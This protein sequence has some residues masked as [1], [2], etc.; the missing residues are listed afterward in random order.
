[1]FGCIW[2]LLGHPSRKQENLQ[3]L[4]YKT[5]ARKDKVFNCWLKQWLKWG[6][7]IH[8]SLLQ[9]YPVTSMTNT[10]AFRAGGSRVICYTGFASDPPQWQKLSNVHS[11]RS[12]EN[13]PK[14]S[15]LKLPFWYCAD[16]LFLFIRTGH[17]Y[18]L[19]PFLGFFQLPFEVFG[20]LGNHCSG[21]FTAEHFISL[22]GH[23]V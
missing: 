3:L 2:K 11:E 22:F 15:C 10:G 13:L 20:I 8:I 21:W 12:T 18:T 16:P 14:Q 5:A 6:W 17:R 19:G 23:L 1:M 4:S 7:N 9:Y